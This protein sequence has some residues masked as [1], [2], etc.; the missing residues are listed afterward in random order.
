MN[1]NWE[2]QLQKKF[3]KAPLDTCMINDAKLSCDQNVLNEQGDSSYAS[4]QSSYITTNIMWS[5]AWNHKNAG[6]YGSLRLEKVLDVDTGVNKSTV[7]RMRKAVPLWPRRLL[8]GE[9]Q[10][11][12]Q[13][14]RHSRNIWT[15][16]LQRIGGPVV[17]V[18]YWITW[19]PIFLVV[20]EGL[21]SR[22][23]IRRSHKFV[24][25]IFVIR[26]RWILIYDQ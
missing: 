17:R 2:I 5:I 7:R 23:N 11:R 19:I 18:Y 1:L 13:T 10:K 3:M 8:D 21:V 20:Q 12:T 24:L 14:T 16:W 26:Q 6:D 4:V 22:M 25:I 15:L 9:G